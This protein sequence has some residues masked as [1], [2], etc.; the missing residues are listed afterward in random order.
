MSSLGLGKVTHLVPPG[1]AL[2]QAPNSYPRP[3]TPKS[4]KAISALVRVTP[5]SRPCLTLSP[6]AFF[7][8]LTPRLAHLHIWL[9]SH[10]TQD[11]SSPQLPSPPLKPPLQCR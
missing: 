10:L 6:D 1:L 3:I 8:L 7:P 9:P 5:G 11:S 4:P 2:S